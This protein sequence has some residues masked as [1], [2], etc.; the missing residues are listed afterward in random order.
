MTKRLKDNITETIKESKVITEIVN[1][2]TEKLFF[3]ASSLS[4]KSK[5]ILLAD[6]IVQVPG[7]FDIPIGPSYVGSYFLHT[8]LSW[9]YAYQSSNQE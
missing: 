4:T 5:Q 7:Y 9:H 8:H 6:K 2:I 3:L 1:A